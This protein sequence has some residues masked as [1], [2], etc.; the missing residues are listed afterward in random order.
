MKNNIFAGIKAW[1]ISFLITGIILIILA[2]VVYCLNCSML[3]VYCGVIASYIIANVVGS[4]LWANYV[5]HKR[6]IVGIVFGGVYFMILLVTS[7]VFATDVGISWSNG[8][9]ALTICLCSSIFG[10]LL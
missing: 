1:L 2:V 7:M 8:V 3:V 4:Y 5:Q 10:S 9:R 6:L